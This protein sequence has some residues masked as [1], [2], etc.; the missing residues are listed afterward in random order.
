VIVRDLGDVER[1]TAGAV[2]EP[3][4]RT[5]Y[6]QLL[7][8]DGLYTVV[9]EKEQVQ[10]LSTSV[11][12]ILAN[13]DEETGGAYDE[14]AMELTEPVEPRWRVGRISIRYEEDADRIVLEVDEFRRGAELEDLEEDDEDDEDDL[15]GDE[16]VDE[17]VDE[18]VRVL[19]A[20]LG[21]PPEEEVERLVARATREQMLALSRHGAAVVTRGRP[22]CQFCANPIDPD[23]HVC[24]AMNGHGK[25]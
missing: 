21:T 20:I 11:L 2:G 23:G 24:P 7:A 9:V 3:G 1:I 15:D 17:D 8:S 13:V 10:L 6:L 12:E 25:H 22:S 14:A 5:F 18:E 16:D 4:R 19:E